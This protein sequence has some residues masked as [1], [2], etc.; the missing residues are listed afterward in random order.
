MTRDKETFHNEKEVNVSVCY[1]NDKYI[2]TFK[3]RE[4]KYMNHNLTKWEGIIDHLTIIARD[5]YTYRTAREK[6]IKHIEDLENIIDQLNL[7]HSTQ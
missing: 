1:I 7:E 2:L 4:S 3:I 6:I 5:I